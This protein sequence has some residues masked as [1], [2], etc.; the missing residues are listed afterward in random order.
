MLFRKDKAPAGLTRERFVDMLISRGLKEV[1]IPG[2]TGLLNGLPLFSHTHEA[3]PRYGDKP[4]H[5]EQP[6]SLFPVAVDFYKSAIKLP[7]WT[8]PGDE[9]IVEK[10]ANTFLSVARELK[11]G[12]HGKDEGKNNISV[13]ARL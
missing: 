10:Y 3:I 2:S 4:W 5:A 7:M 9:E 12:K 8:M 6:D 13:M 11:R 1:D